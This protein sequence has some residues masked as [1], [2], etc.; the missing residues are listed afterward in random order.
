MLAAFLVSIS[1]FGQE[2]GNEADFTVYGASF[3]PE[4]P[5]TAKEMAGVYENIQKGDSL[6]VA[7]KANVVEVCKAK[8]CWMTLQLDDKSKVLVKFKDY[9]FFVP[10]DLDNDEVIVSGTAFV[11][12][13]SVEEQRHYARDAGAKASEV[14]KITAPKKTLRFEATGVLVKE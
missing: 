13:L 9:G 5:Q 12:A 10:T 6:Q 8:G 1:C 4:N 3:A 2:A 7:F 14:E 11:E